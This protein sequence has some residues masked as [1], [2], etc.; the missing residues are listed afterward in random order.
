MGFGNFAFLAA[1]GSLGDGGGLGA[2]RCFETFGGGSAGSLFGLAQS[3]THGGVG[4]VHLMSAGGLS[5][6]TRGGL[7]CCSGGFGFGLGEQCLFADLFGGAMSQLRAVLAAGGGEVAVLG[8]VKIGPGVENR[9]IFR[10]LG[11]GGIIVFIGAARVHDLPILCFQLR[12]F[13]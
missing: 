4:V 9:H 2:S 5:C 13:Y 10:S 12:C 3:T 7:R 6:V 1:C 8:S 11:Y